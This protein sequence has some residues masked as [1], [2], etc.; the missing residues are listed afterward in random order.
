M[1]TSKVI[2]ISLD[3]VA[4]ALRLCFFLNIPVA[5]WGRRGVGKSS[6]VAQSVPTGWKL[7]DFR[8][9]D[10]EASDIGGIPFPVDSKEDKIKR[11]EYLMT[12]LLPFDSQE[13]CIVLLD[14]FD[15]SPD[16]SVQNAML[17]LVL[18]RK[19][20]GHDLSPNA[21]I[22]IAGN[23]A[24]DI[25]TIPLSSAS[26]GRMLHLYIETDDDSAVKAWQNWAIE[27]GEVSTA[28]TSFAEFKNEVWRSAKDAGELEELGSPTPRTFVMADRV[29]QAARNESVKF[30]VSDLLLPMIAGCIGR[31]AALE[32]LSWYKICEQAP[33]MEEIADNPTGA[34]LPTEDG[35][36]CALGLTIARHA[37]EERNGTVDAYATYISRWTP[38]RARFAFTHLLREQSKA[39]TSP[40]YLKWNKAQEAKL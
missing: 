33:T 5:L 29:Y 10:K 28:L 35:V 32:L 16:L 24:T 26:A 8:A 27:S 22:V 15:R 6:V 2:K 34:K 13:K 19:V 9:S 17:Q 4:R 12:K 25:G 31:V 40:A 38:E 21:R 18:D 30:E 11:I 23:G 14:E 3:K 37:K 39:A 7:Y 20:N 36:Y 1:N